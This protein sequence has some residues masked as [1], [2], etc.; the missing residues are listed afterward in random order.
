MTDTMTRAS[1]LTTLDQA[2]DGRISDLLTRRVSEGRKAAQ[3]RD[4]LRDEH[5][6]TVS[7]RTVRRW[8]ADIERAAS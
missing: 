4:E 6:I 5:N 1:A 3:I 7:E 2:L 8:L